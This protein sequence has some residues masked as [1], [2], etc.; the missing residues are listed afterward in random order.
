MPPVLSMTCRCGRSVSAPC[1]NLHD[2]PSVLATFV[3]WSFDERGFVRC[4]ECIKAPAEAVGPAQG[5]L[6]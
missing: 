6:L 2:L 3:G 4:P 1:P 5:R